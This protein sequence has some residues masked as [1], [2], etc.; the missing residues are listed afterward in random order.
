MWACWI[1]PLVEALGHSSVVHLS[2]DLLKL[3]LALYREVL[4]GGAGTGVVGAV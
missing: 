4:S 1:L 2:D 3:E